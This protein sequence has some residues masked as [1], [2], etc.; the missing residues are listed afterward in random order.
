MKNNCKD[1]TLS[2]SN[3]WVDW[4]VK[5][6]I[7]RMPRACLWV[8]KMKTTE[9]NCKVL[10]LSSSNDWAYWTA[11]TRRRTRVCLRV[12]MNTTRNNCKDSALSSSNSWACWVAKHALQRLTRSCLW[13]EKMKTMEN[14]SNDSRSFQQALS[15]F[16]SYAWAEEADWS[17]FTSRWGWRAPKQ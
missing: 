17:L 14:N 3:C 1:S 15:A 5:R 12:K 8:K 9:N 13:V 6:V 10:T 11:K 7:E 4:V 2:S 16:R